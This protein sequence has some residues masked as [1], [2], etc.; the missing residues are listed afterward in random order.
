MEKDGQRLT[1]WGCA[2][3]WGSYDHP[4]EMEVWKVGCRGRRRVRG[5]GVSPP[6]TRRGGPTGERHLRRSLG[7]RIWAQASPLAALGLR[8]SSATFTVLP[9]PDRAASQGWGS[10]LDPMW[11]TRRWGLGGQLHHENIKNLPTLAG[12]LGFR[13]GA[14]D[15]SSEAQNLKNFLPLVGQGTRDRKDEAA[16]AE[17]CV[18]S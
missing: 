10:I 15:A 7:S 9:R 8:V 16:A 5:R 13:F 3:L 4:D 1:L 11:V 2:A 17:S 18:S 12:R 14:P 6:C